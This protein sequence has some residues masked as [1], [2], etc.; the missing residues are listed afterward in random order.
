[1]GDIE[2]GK[3]RCGC[4]KK[5]DRNAPLDTMFPKTG[6]GWGLVL[7]LHQIVAWSRKRKFMHPMNR[8]GHSLNSSGEKL[9]VHGGQA[10][11]ASSGRS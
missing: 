4:N 8:S 2:K 5:N 3:G 7:G 9:P 11:P 6:F 1:L 10:V